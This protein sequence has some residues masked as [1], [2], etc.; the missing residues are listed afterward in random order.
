LTLGN[1]SIV[2]SGGTIDFDDENL[3]TDGDIRVTSNSNRLELGASATNAYVRYD[4]TDLV[5][6]DDNIGAKTLSQLSSQ[7]LDPTVGAGEDF[8]ITEGKFTWTDS[9]AEIA[10]AWTFSNA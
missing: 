10:G 7:V 8:T 5:L 2:D 9:A 3:T 4:G 6:Y 1:G